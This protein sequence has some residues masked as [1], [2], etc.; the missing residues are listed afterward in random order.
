MNT[1]RWDERYGADEFF[2]GTEPNGFLA[3]VAPGLKRGKALCIAA[4]EGRNSVFLAQL[5]F[6]VTAMDASSAGMEKTARLAAK[7]G[8]TVEPV[9][10]DLAE[11]AIGV[12]AWDLIV[13]VFCHMARELR[14]DVHRRVVDGL[15]PGGVFVLEAY[16]PDQLAYGTG[17]PPVA[18]LLAHKDELESELFGLDFETLRETERDVTEGRGHTGRAAVA[19]IVARKPM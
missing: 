2:F 5:G 6:A 7:R 16:T 8:V 19:Q 1:S 15:K 13:S 10:A 14:T 3:T 11:F 17:G 18:E 4:G 9:V 12:E